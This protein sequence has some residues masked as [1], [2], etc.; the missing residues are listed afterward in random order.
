VDKKLRTDQWVLHLG[1][2]VLVS[3]IGL[4]LSSL[5]NAPLM[6]VLGLPIYWVGFL[7]PERGW[8]AWTDTEFAP[9]PV[10]QLYK[11]LTPS[12]LSRLSAS[13]HFQPF[14]LFPLDTPPPLLVRMDSKIMFVRVVENWSEGYQVVVTGLEMRG[15]S[16]HEV[17]RV[18]VEEVGEEGEEGRWVSGCLLE[19]LGYFNITTY[20]D[21]SSVLT[22]VLDHPDTLK[23]FPD[24]L[25]KCLVYVVWRELE[26]LGDA[27]GGGVQGMDALSR[28]H[29]YL[30]SFD[31]ARRSREVEEA[32]I[33]VAEIGYSMLLG[34]GAASA[35]PL[36]INVL[37]KLYSGEVSD[38]VGMDL[39]KWML[40]R[41]Q[42]GVRR[43]S[44]RAGRLAVKILWQAQIDGGGMESFQELL[45]SLD[46]HY[47]N[48]HLTVHQTPPTHNKP[49]QFVE[50]FTWSE[51]VERK[52]PDV[53]LFGVANKDEDLTTK[54]GAETNM[55][56]TSRRGEE[57]RVTA[58]V[59]SINE[60]CKC[61]VGRVPD[62]VVKGI[63]ANMAFEM[64]YLTNDDD[65]E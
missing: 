11:H 31:H 12:L 23:L 42:A 14:R 32:S 64:Y 29:E 26:S 60:G 4:V 37:N 16:C 28:W 62:A 8:W 6:P 33:L 9:H 41:A 48:W 35:P 17:E 5:L 57:A 53:F 47:D 7:R 40:D 38:Q 51:A 21:S 13:T 2:S 34:G 19:P 43:A 54:E 50:E 65:G 44:V 15:T 45:E 63:W 46:D 30:R 3:P 36:N 49:T 1:L 59:L 24:L 18:V 52:V 25:F 27:G 20:S 56:G 22:G 55:Q 61:Y 58:R 10:S 39:R